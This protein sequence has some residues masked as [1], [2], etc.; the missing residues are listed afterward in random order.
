MARTVLLLVLAAAAPAAYSPTLDQRAIDDAI[1]IGQSYSDSVRNRFH[2][3]YRAHVARAPVDY[4][5]V[6][7]PFRRVVLAAEDRA[8]VGD[9]LLAQRDARAVIAQQGQAIDLAVELTFH[10][11]NTYVGVPDYDVALEAGAWV[12]RARRLERLSRFTPRVTG[13]PLAGVGAGATQG[14]QPLLG[15]TV[16]ARFERTDLDPLAGYDVVIREAGK[17][18]ARGRIELGT[19]R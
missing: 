14:S 11:L 9:R 13:V 7:T 6:I 12:L 16:I 5:D 19:L 10:P 8:R 18:L 17:E 1:A 3:T 4:I 15:A 2:L